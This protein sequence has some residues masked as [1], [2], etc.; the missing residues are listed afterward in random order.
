M[1]RYNRLWLVEK[2]GFRSPRQAFEDFQ[3][4]KVA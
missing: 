1:E 4:K 3:L 2:L